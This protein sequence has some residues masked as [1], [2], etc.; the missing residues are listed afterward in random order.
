MPAENLPRPY[1]VKS[2][3]DHL[4]PFKVTGVKPGF[5][6]AEENGLKAFE[7]I[8]ESSFPGKWKVLYFYVKDFSPLCPTEIQAFSHLA[9]EFEA[10]DAILMGGSTDNEWAKLAW[11]RESPEL[12]RLNHYQFS[13]TS[14][15]LI[16]QLG[17]RDR[18]TGVAMRATF[19]VDP[20]NT[21]QY[22]SVH[23]PLVG[24]NPEEILRVLDALLT[25]EPC[26]AGRPTGGETL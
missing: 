10:R 25:G 6:Q 14:G 22:V 19:I 15:D 11:R 5:N 2:V 24:R 16:D 21:I 26:P 17:V 12:S 18:A 4:E 1:A 7:A 13:D 3:G 9:P 8:T 23:N 20:D